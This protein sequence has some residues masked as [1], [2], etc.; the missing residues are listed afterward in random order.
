MC[1]RTG[2]YNVGILGPSSVN[3][4]VVKGKRHEVCRWLHEWV[5]SGCQ[6]RLAL[7]LQ[8]LGGEGMM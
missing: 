7:E 6:I 1:D 2:G 8:L 3:T 4:L 5:M